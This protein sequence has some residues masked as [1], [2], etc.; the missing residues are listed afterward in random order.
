MKIIKRG[1]VPGKREHT[2]TCHNCGTVVR[3]RQEEGKVTHDQRDGDFVTVTCPVCGNQ[4]HSDL[5]K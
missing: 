2:G 4:I 1:K 5:R 3:F